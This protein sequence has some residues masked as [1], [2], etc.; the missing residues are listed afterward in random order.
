MIGPGQET[1]LGRCEH[2]E[3]KPKKMGLHGHFRLTSRTWD[4]LSIALILLILA[5]HARFALLDSRLPTNTNSAYYDLPDFYRLLG[6]DGRA[7]EAIRD[8]FLS[9]GGWYNLLI[10]GL[11]HV[12]GKT[13][14][15]LQALNALW[16]ALV[17][18]GM[19]IIARRFWGSAA[20]FVAICLLPPGGE[21]LVLQARISCVHI[22]ELALLLGIVVALGYDRRLHRWSTVILIGLAGAGALAMRQSSLIWIGTLL[23][24]LLSSCRLVVWRPGGLSKILTI[25]AL[26]SVAAPPYW[27][28]LRD[29]VLDKID[30]RNAFIGDFSL[31][32]LYSSMLSDLGAVLFWLGLAAM[33]AALSRWRPAPRLLRWV[34]LCWFIVPGILFAL[35]VAGTQDF[36][37]YYVAFSLLVSAGLSRIPHWPRPLFLLLLVPWLHAYI[38]QWL[39]ESSPWNMA[40]LPFHSPGQAEA[41][42][43]NIY[44]VHT[45]QRASDLKMLLAAT[46]PR[47]AGQGC[48]IYTSGGLILPIPYSYGDSTGLFFLGWENVNSEVMPAPEDLDPD[49]PEALAGYICDSPEADQ[50]GLEARFEER[51]RH[52]MAKHNYEVIWSKSVDRRCQFFWSTPD[53]VVRHPERLKTLNPPA[54]GLR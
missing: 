21:A 52:L 33:A 4:L 41:G 46:C 16:L 43:R 39:P 53:G 37:M 2:R 31:E 32:L 30:H 45:G 24:L 47:V 19:A 6:Q 9:I 28:H 54:R 27:L 12:F 36:P 35:F 17:L 10:A 44:R 1:P 25:F 20:A 14:L 26:W 22:P 51:F 11:L 23:P 18:C 48:R 38:P 42:I 8:A 7:V 49:P 40:G 15:V 50:S 5:A 29:Y 3:L 34:L 13:P